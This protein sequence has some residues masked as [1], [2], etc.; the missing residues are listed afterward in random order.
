[1]QYNMTPNAVAQSSVEERAAF[2]TRTYVHLFGAIFAFVAIEALLFA[3]GIANPILYAV[4]SSRFAWMLFLGGFIAV[5]YVA[6]RWARS[7]TS[8]GMQ[9][10][11]LGLYV[12]A[13]AIMFVP[14]IAMA[15]YVDAGILPKAG[16][17]TLVLFGG[18]TG[19]V[20][21]T[22]KDFSFMRGALMLGG[23]AAMGLVVSSILFGFS[24][25][26]IFSWAM[27]A[28]AAG[29][30]L[31]NTSNV[32]LYYRTDQHVSAALTLFADVAL[33]LWYVIRILLNSR[34]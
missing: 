1:M 20:F 3:T 29:Y 24:L 8:L 14:L 26:V 10:A 22:R 11:G 31:Y 23:F 21:I 6:D 7:A 33:M 25:G 19:V 12:V 2:I 32:M 5:S 4:S 28:L 9:Y 18:L 34:R 15:A 17:I 30:I 16:I 13:E 27:L